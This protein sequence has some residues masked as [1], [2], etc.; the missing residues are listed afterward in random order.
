MS[1]LEQ[2]IL[3]PL[4][5]VM[6]AIIILV[7]FRPFVI[8]YWKIDEFIELLSEIRDRLS[9]SKNTKENRKLL[10]DLRDTPSLKQ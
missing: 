7:I 10:E 2:S 3:F 1:P 5:Y 4:I 9:D 8:W 6:V